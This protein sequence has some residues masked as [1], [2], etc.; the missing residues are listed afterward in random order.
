MTPSSRKPMRNAPLRPD[1]ATAFPVNLILFDPG[2]LDRPLPLSDPRAAHLIRVLRRGVG[3]RFDAGIVGGPR[4]KGVVRSLTN[5]AVGLAF[6]PG[7]IPPPPDPIHL[8]IALP[9]PQTARKILNEAAALGGAS[10]RF[11]RG[12]KGEPGYSQSSLWTSGE[13]RRH[14]MAGAAQA[15]DPHLPEVGHFDGL[16]DAI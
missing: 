3:D 7:A 12:E 15:F 14:L 6:E 1:W 10:L 8:L 13:W 9:R 16:A 2:E 4:G 5:D 11:F